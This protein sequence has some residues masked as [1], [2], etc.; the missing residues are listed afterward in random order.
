MST[1]KSVDEQECSASEI[2]F[3]STSFWSLISVG[4]RVLSQFVL[5]KIIAVLAGAAAYGVMGQ[6]LSFVSIIQVASGGIIR[7]GMTKYSSEYAHD[8]LKLRALISTGFKFT[9]FSSLL[10]GFFIA[11]FSRPIAY[12]VFLSYGYYKVVLLFG[13]TLFGFSINQLYM[14]LLNGLNRMRAMALLSA[15]GSFVSLFLVGIGVYIGGVRGALYGFVLAQFFIFVC[16]LSFSA[17]LGLR[18]RILNTSFDYSIGNKLMRF[19][20]MSIVSMISIPLCEVGIRLYVVK[21]TSWV[22]VGYWQGMTRISDAYLL[23]AMSIISTYALPKYSRIKNRKKLKEE[24]FGL[25]LKL[26][27]LV[28]VT[29]LA[30]F[31]LKD[32]VIMV[33]FTKS[34][35][36]MRHLFGFQLLGDIAKTASFIVGNVLIAKARVKVFVLFEL[37]T[38]SVYFFASI[39]MYRELGLIGLPAAFLLTYLFQFLVNM[40]IFRGYVRQ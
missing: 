15:L 19:S 8:P 6:F 7:S 13:L 34:F 17:T 36:P 35:L 5:A 27:P 9:F 22:D 21:H 4:A 26:I 32:F 18:I 16:A 39:A 33:L 37:A 20:L 40:L 29:A 1:V 11:V 3:L 28:S 12:F 31:L 2:R 14:S 24:V 23:L 25:L 30:I 38:A 10:A